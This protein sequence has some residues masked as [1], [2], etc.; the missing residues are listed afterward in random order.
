MLKCA[1]PEQKLIAHFLG[2]LPALPAVEVDDVENDPPGKHGDSR[3]DARVQLQVAGKP[4][5]LLVQ[6]R[7]AT[8]PRDILSRP[9]SHGGSNL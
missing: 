7:R 4:L 2:A 3:Y 8:L 5:V 6:A 9:G 1:P